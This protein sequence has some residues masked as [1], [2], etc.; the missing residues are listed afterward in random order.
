MVTQHIETLIIGAGQAGLSTGHHLRRLGRPFLIVDRDKRVGDNWRRHYDSLR[1]YTPAKYTRLPGMSF[2][3][4]DRWSY[5]SKDEVADFLERYALHQELP[6]RMSTGVDRLTARPGGGYSA[7][8][9]ADTITCDNVVVATGTFG[10]T[11]YR[12]EFASELDPGITQ[13]HSSEYRR[14]DQLREGPALV[15]GASHSGTDIAYELAA[16]RPTILC[17]RDCGQ[18]PLRWDS[19][20]IRVALP[21]LVFL[22]RHILT[23][24]TP[25]GRK[26]MREVR[27][28]GGPMLRVK[29]ADLAARDVRRS[30]AR[31]S[32]VRD[33]MPELDD[34]TVLDVR[35]V[36]WATGFRQ[37]FDW[38]EVPVIGAD[39]WPRE[40]RGVVDEAPGLFFCGLSFQY[41]FS[42]MVFPGVG[43]DAEYVARRIAARA[44]ERIA[45]REAA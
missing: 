31:V 45:H 32:G 33:G 18:I 21:V 23:R 17:G 35:N 36:I 44:K 7:R 41:A 2:P 24:R 30:T 8:I 37:V 16:A 4:A 5:P 28:H 38:I 12:P 39:G 40:Y 34:G 15:V 6:V 11:P 43:R 42:S 29:R 10:R 14:P 22:W 1:L 20:R 27:F 13:L 25:M 9:G 3:A 26:E 19:R